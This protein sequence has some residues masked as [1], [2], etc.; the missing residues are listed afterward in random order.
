MGNMDTLVR[1]QIGEILCEKGYLDEARLVQALRQHQGVV[2]GQSHGSSS[3]LQFPYVTR[4]AI[5]QK[6]VK[7]LRPQRQFHLTGFCTGQQLAV[8]AG[9]ELLFKKK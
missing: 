5:A 9:T 4:P 6:P 1:K 3:V 2:A 8:T 7:Q